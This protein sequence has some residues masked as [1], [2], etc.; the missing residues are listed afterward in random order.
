MGH[1]RAIEFRLARDN[2]RGVGSIRARV[3]P[4]LEKIHVSGAQRRRSP[5]NV[6]ELIR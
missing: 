6:D 5:G 4:G 3:P 1:E 2:D